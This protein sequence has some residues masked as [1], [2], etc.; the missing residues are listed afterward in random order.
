[1]T[2]SGPDHWNLISATMQLPLLVIRPWYWE[3][4]ENRKAKEDTKQGYASD[5]WIKSSFNLYI[6]SSYDRWLSPAN[7]CV[8]HWHTARSTPQ[9]SLLHNSR[10]CQHFHCISKIK[11]FSM[12]CKI[13][14]YS[15]TFWL[16]SMK[17]STRLRLLI[18]YLTPLVFLKYP[19]TVRSYAGILLHSVS[20]SM[21]S[22]LLFKRYG[23]RQI[24]RL[25]LFLYSLTLTQGLSLIK[26]DQGWLTL[27][28]SQPTSKKGG[29]TPTVKDAGSCQVSSRRT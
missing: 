22:D 6:I 16:L 21:K 25:P 18:Y 29:H 8:S 13:S 14:N 10:V 27:P 28:R 7:A 19:C 9:T 23:W 11:N 4:S 17:P 24:I 20:N 5:N 3:W 12:I 15:F 26:A 2:P 1:M